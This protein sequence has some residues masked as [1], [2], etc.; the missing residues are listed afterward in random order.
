MTAQGILNACAV[1]FL[2]CSCRS[3]RLA[4]P[5][6]SGSGMEKNILETEKEKELRQRRKKRGAFFGF[7]EKKK[8]IFTVNFYLF[9]CFTICF[10]PFELLNFAC[11]GSFLPLKTAVFT[12]LGKSYQQFA[13]LRLIPLS[14]GFCALFFFPFLSFFHLFKN[15]RFG[16][17]RGAKKQPRKTPKNDQKQTEKTNQKFQKEKP[18]KDQ[19]RA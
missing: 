17:V 14:I 13:F 16:G 15:R 18:E 5:R 8:R 4:V 7:A 3:N 9:A 10:L 19:N 2:R 12:V 11:F 6:C 1:I